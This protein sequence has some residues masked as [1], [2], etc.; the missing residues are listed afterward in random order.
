MSNEELE[1]KKEMI[2]S[3]DGIDLDK[4]DI[5]LNNAVGLGSTSKRELHDAVKQRRKQ[6]L[7]TFSVS[8]EH[9]EIDSD[10][11]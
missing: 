10:E 7:D 2:S 1:N 9:G 5:I 3:L 4:F 6:L 8:V 11:F